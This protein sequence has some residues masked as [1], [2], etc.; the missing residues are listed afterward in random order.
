M[1]MAR[2]A[3]NGC[4]P[5]NR[6]RLWAV[7]Y[8]HPAGA[9]II[10]LSGYIL[11]AIWCDLILHMSDLNMGGQNDP[12]GKPPVV[13]PERQILLKLNDIIWN[14]MFFTKW[15]CSVFTCHM[16]PYLATFC[17][18]LAGHQM[19]PLKQPPSDVRPPS[20]KEDRILR[21]QLCKPMDAA[22]STRASCHSNSSTFEVPKSG[23]SHYLYLFIL[24]I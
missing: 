4:N 14:W 19:I 23:W 22:A 15:I 13:V 3:E 21:P 9:S 8:L 24:M 1:L 10:R 18:S 6:S 11:R 7:A 17:I 12:C 5:E 2:L 20:H 16:L